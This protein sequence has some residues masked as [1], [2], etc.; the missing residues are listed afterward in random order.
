MEVNIRSLV[1]HIVTLCDVKT[2]RLVSPM[3]YQFSGNNSLFRV[4][5]N[6]TNLFY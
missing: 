2:Q 1:L 6:V 5:L 3:R 4:S